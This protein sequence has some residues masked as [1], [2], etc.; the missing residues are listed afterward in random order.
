M[1]I[2]DG[3]TGAKCTITEA[4]TETAQDVAR[5]I[6]RLCEWAD[7]FG[8]EN[9]KGTKILEWVNNHLKNPSEATTIRL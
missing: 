5:R 4:T 1:R 9:H 6:S 7:H 3:G 8:L 2:T